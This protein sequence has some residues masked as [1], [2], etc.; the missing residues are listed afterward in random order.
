MKMEEVK[1]ELEIDEFIKNAQ[2]QP[3]IAD[4]M[5]VYGEYVEMMEKSRDYLKEVKPKVIISST[6]DSA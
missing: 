6:S 3:G 4:L 1:E 5:F 2:K